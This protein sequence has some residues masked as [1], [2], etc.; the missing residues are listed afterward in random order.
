VKDGALRQSYLEACER[1]DYEVAHGLLGEIQ[2]QKK[3]PPLIPK[4]AQ[5]VSLEEV[6]DYVNLLYPLMSVYLHHRK[7]NELF[8]CSSALIDWLHKKRP[9]A[10]TDNDYRYDCDAHH[11]LIVFYESQQDEKAIEA[12]CLIIIT[13]GNSVQIK[14]QQDWRA[15]LMAYR[16]LSVSYFNQTPRD[17]R[18]FMSMVES[19]NAIVQQIN[20]K[21]TEDLYCLIDTYHNA[22]LSLNVEEWLGRAD[23]YRGELLKFLWK[24][25]DK[26]KKSF[27]VMCNLVDEIADADALRKTDSDVDVILK[28]YLSFAREDPAKQERLAVSEEREKLIKMFLTANEK[29]IWENAK[30]FLEKI[31]TEHL[32]I[33]LDFP[34]EAA[35]QPDAKIAILLGM[36]TH[37]G[38]GSWHDG[39]KALAVPFLEKATKFIVVMREASDELWRHSAVAAYVC[40]LNYFDESNFLSSIKAC[41][42]SLSMFECIRE[43]SD[44]DRDCI[45]KALD[46]LEK[47]I[48]AN[49][50]VE[51][52]YSWHATKKAAKKSLNG[53]CVP[54][55]VPPKPILFPP[56]LAQ[57][58][59]SLEEACDSRDED[60]AE[61][62]MQS[63]GALT[64]LDVYSPSDDAKV[65][66][67]ILRCFAS[68]FVSLA[69][70]YFSCEPETDKEYD[71]YQLAL[72]WWKY[73]KIKS[74]ED[75]ETYISLLDNVCKIHAQRKNS[76][77][78]LSTAD[79]IV[80]VYENIPSIQNERHAFL[81]LHVSRKAVDFC[82]AENDSESATKWES[83]VRACR[84]FLVTKFKGELE[85]L[86]K[87]VDEQLS[88]K[89]WDA[90]R[91]VI[92]D[93]H[94]VL[95]RL[96]KLVLKGEAA[97]R[98]LI[99]DH[100]YIFGSCLYRIFQMYIRQSLLKEAYSVLSEIKWWLGKIDYFSDDAELLRIECDVCENAFDWRREKKWKMDTALEFAR[101]AMPEEDKTK[102]AEIEVRKKAKAD[103]ENAEREQ[104]RQQALQENARKRQEECLQIAA[105][106]AQERHEAEMIKKNQI[107]KSTFVGFYRKFK[108]LSVDNVKLIYR[109][110]RKLSNKILN[111]NR[112]CYAESS[113]RD[114]ARQ[115]LILACEALMEACDVIMSCFLKS[116]LIDYSKVT[117]EELLKLNPVFVRAW[118]LYGKST[119][120]QR[121]EQEVEVCA[122]K[123][124]KL[125][126]VPVSFFRY[127]LRNV[128]QHYEI[129]ELNHL[130][131]EF[132]KISIKG[133]SC[134]GLLND[135]VSSRQ[136][137]DFKKFSESEKK[138]GAIWKELYERYPGFEDILHDESHELYEI[139]SIL[140]SCHDNFGKINRVADTMPSSQRVKEMCEK[141]YDR[142]EEVERRRKICSL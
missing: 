82:N 133:F 64:N 86:I 138:L 40:S 103:A 25:F 119:E 50:P 129:I 8:K 29:K 41:K 7:I 137:N 6:D 20:P 125:H 14:T 96:N 93:A 135:L 88:Q 5:D 117:Y 30:L 116:K 55:S 84:S 24:N 16:R 56:T 52:I 45:A 111:L 42:R 107:E 127:R 76:E 71:A 92:Y 53:K 128:V 46:T 65:S 47:S 39:K 32:G 77:D 34:Y 112:K 2:K 105:K 131:P 72:K 78:Y 73:I 102:K 63:I 3:F 44:Q 97:E 115:H 74:A 83:K 66:D 1:K 142:I 10:W 87:V 85:H 109:C 91:S 94:N 18:G 108:N 141:L 58:K 43:K 123:L 124:H 15:L 33:N 11:R 13:Q 132:A 114:V 27:V 22:G 81:L 12:A 21:T 98:E 67:E 31:A 136:L 75:W 57:L 101:R 35:D 122:Q 38:M 54:K 130:S 9:E 95:D 4:M 110:H 104:K 59:Q 62:L 140:E 28:E 100:A 23:H 139:M 134:E 121:L 51:K 120:W 90:A 49:P 26:T 19:I 69:Q 118:N 80:Y 89:K 99:G 79:G 126:I 70:L 37:L 60:S 106:E 113:P 68:S 36:L 17:A 48:R 61:L